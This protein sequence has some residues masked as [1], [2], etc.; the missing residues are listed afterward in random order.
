MR[1]N[2]LRFV[3][4]V[5]GAIG[6]LTMAGTALAQTPSP[7]KE[8]P[9]TWGPAPDGFPPGARFAVESGDPTKTGTFVVHLSM[10]AGYKIPPHWHPTD[11]RVGVVSGTLLVGMGDV[12][13]TTKAMKLMPGDTVTM[14][15]PMHHFAVAQGPT[16]VRVRAEGPFAITY[17]N[18]ADDPRKKGER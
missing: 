4:G 7:A 10:P 5:L 15:S 17:V 18:P 11:E 1:R 6:A 3:P 9:L 16:E 2:I 13:D 8:P 14:K 12:I